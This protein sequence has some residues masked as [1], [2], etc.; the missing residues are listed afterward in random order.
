[1]KLTKNSQDEYSKRKYS[2]LLLGHLYYSNGQNDKAFQYFDS[3]KG[4]LLKTVKM[5]TQKGN[6]A[7]YCLA[8]CIT[9]TGKMI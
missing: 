5:S 7:Y 2:L 9:V 6:I 4:S 1:R 3:V 8:I